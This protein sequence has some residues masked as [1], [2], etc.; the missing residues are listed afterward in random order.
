MTCDQAR[1][2]LNPYLDRELEDS[3]R[4]LLEQHLHTCGGCQAEK[5][6]LEKTLRIIQSTKELENSDR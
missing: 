1:G 3:L 6:L 2:M 5:A 4:P